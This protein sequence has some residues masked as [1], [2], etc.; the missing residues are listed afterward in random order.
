[1]IVVVMFFISRGLFVNH[2]R[3]FPVVIMIIMIASGQERNRGQD[4]HH[5]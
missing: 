4:S 5:Q 2:C 3:M 1:M